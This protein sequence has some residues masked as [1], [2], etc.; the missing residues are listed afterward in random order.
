[1]MTLSINELKIQLSTREFLTPAKL[2]TIK[3]GGGEDL[4]RDT[5]R[6]IVVTTIK[7]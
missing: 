5:M 7:K 3:G 1:M 6:I 4:R 2:G